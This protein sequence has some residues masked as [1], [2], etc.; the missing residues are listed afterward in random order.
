[1]RFCADESLSAV[2]D[3]RRGEGNFPVEQIKFNY[4]NA[5]LRICVDEGHCG[6][7]VGQRLREPIPFSDFVDLVLKI[8]AILDGQDF[9]RAF[10]R[11][12]QFQ[13]KAS[14]PIAF[15]NYVDEMMSDEAVN[16]AFGKVTTVIVQIVTRQNTSWQGAVFS[17]D[18]TK[19]TAFQS[20]L[21]FLSLM[22][23]IM[24]KEEN[25]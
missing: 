10:Q 3:G 8:E 2:F 16:G 1:M 18:K 11:K 24:Q 5:M 15:A 9:P 22:D 17:E 6:T 19:R 13:E 14:A 12:R 21:E 23:D 4:N 7:L 20:D 25:Q